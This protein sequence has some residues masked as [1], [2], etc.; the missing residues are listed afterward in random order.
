MLAWKNGTEKAGNIQSEVQW[1]ARCSPAHP[2]YC[3]CLY[4]QHTKTIRNAATLQN[5][6]TVRIPYGITQSTMPSISFFFFFFQIKLNKAAQR[7]GKK[8]NMIQLPLWLPFWHYLCVLMCTNTCNYKT[9]CSWV[10]RTSI[11]SHAYIP[12]HT[13][14]FNLTFRIHTSIVHQ[15]V[16]GAVCTY[17]WLADMQEMLPTLINMLP[18]PSRTNSTFEIFPSH[19]RIETVPDVGGVEIT[20]NT[21]HGLILAVQML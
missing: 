9:S 12:L 4:A 18:T 19:Q 8:M 5:A 21:H 14:H 13:Q 10:T 2:K 1:A 6:P 16:L 7:A 17:S 15:N 3:T 20:D 11:V